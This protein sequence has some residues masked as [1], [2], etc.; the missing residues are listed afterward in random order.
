VNAGVFTLE[1]IDDGMRLTPDASDVRGLLGIGGFPEV[2]STT[3]RVCP[4]GKIE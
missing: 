2:G 4:A 3:T 1:E